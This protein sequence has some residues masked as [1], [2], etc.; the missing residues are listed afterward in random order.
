MTSL[1][2]LPEQQIPDLALADE[3][4]I[5]HDDLRMDPVQGAVSVCVA[6]RRT[7]CEVPAEMGRLERVAASVEAGKDRKV[8]VDPGQ[9]QMSG[10]WG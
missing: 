3:D 5:V 1:A 10:P 8:A 9:L 7:G 2:T 4:L 6:A